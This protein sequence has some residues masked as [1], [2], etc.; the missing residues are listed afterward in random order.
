MFQG[1]ESQFTASSL[2]AA[3]EE[4]RAGNANVVNMSLGGASS[5]TFELNKVNSLAEAGITL[6]AASGNSGSGPN[7]QEYPA[8]YDNVISVGAVDSNQN[9]AEF[10]THNAQVDVSAPGV[11]VVS[12]SHLCVDCY[13]SYSGTS[14]ASPHV[15]GV[16]ALLVSRYGSTKTREEIRAAIEMSAQDAGACGLD[17]L[18]GHGIVDVVAAAAY[19]DSGSTATERSGCIST[20]VTVLTD[21]Y[22]SETSYEIR[23]KATGVTVYKNGPFEDSQTTYTDEFQLP[24]GCYEFEMKDAFGKSV[25][26]HPPVMGLS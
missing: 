3:M 21:N 2:S 24:P 8:A 11:D 14:M 26:V 9:Y 22:A 19:L 23:D 25:R 7:P 17:R 18:Y 20:K 15:A 13:A 16:A 6:V 1:V 5:S 12:L 10:S 4:C